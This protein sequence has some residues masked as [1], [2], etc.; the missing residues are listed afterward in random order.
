MAWLETKLPK[1]KKMTRIKIKRDRTG[2]D[3]SLM[4]D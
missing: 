4:P 2:S 3:Q 1:F